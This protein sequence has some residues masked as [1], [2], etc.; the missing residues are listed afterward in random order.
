MTDTLHR[1]EGDDAVSMG[2]YVHVLRVLGIAEDLDAVARRRARAQAARSG[3]P[4]PKDRG[5]PER[6]PVSSKSRALRDEVLV[7]LDAVFVPTACPIGTL[8]HAGPQPEL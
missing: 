2:T 4:G 7:V 3:T 6:R 1:R 8:Y 5:G